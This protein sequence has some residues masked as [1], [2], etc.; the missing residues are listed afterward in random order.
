MVTKLQLESVW[1]MRIENLSKGYKR[2]IALAAALL[3]SPDVL[4]L[5]EPTDG[6]DPNQKFAIRG[7][8]KE[9][10][11]DKVVILST[12][13]LEEVEAICNRVLVVNNGKIITD[14]KVLELVKSHAT[15]RKHQLTLQAKESVD[16]D[17]YFSNFSAITHV[18]SK[19][20]ADEKVVTVTI[21]TEKDANVIPDLLARL[22]DFCEKII[23]VNTVPYQLEEVFRKITK[24]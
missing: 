19:S 16:V 2:R 12:H 14:G 24:D 23:D 13:I 10:A 7:L 21:T 18:T 8:I 3:H 9:I 5:D 1:H 15:D 17:A 11:K 6:L 20:S 4:I 22:D